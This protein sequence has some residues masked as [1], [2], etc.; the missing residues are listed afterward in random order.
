MKAVKLVLERY[1]SSEVQTIGKLFGVSEVGHIVFEC[2][3]LELPWKDNKTDISCIPTGTYTVKRRYSKKYKNHLHITE[4]TDRTHI[5][6]HAGNYNKD[7]KGCVLVGKLGYLNNDDIVDVVS[8]KK[9]LKKLL[10]I[11]ESQSIELVVVDT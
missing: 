8:S 10:N 7:T 5:L 6:V 11:I 3:T 2:D 4:V 9:T 1:S